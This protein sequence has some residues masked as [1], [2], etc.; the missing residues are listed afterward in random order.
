MRLQTRVL[1]RTGQWKHYWH[2]RELLLLLFGVR[3][4]SSPPGREGVVDG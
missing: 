3:L 1:G 4:V 2:L